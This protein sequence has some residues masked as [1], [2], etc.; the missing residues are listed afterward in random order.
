M[1]TITRADIAPGAGVP[2]RRRGAWMPGSV[3]PEILVNW[4]APGANY[5]LQ[6]TAG[7]TSGEAMLIGRQGVGAFSLFLKSDG[8][9]QFRENSVVLFEAPAG[10]FSYDGQP[11][12]FRMNVKGAGLFADAGEV[13]LDGRV[14]ASASFASR[15]V[16]T[17]SAGYRI[18]SV[19][20]FG[21]AVGGTIYDVRF[22]DPAS[23]ANTA[24]FPLD[25]R[26]SAGDYPN[27]HPGSSV[28][29]ASITGTV[30]P[31]LVNAPGG[32]GVPVYPG[33]VVVCL[34]RDSAVSVSTASGTMLL[35]ADL[36]PFGWY[37]SNGFVVPY[38]H[39][40]RLT[41]T[42]RIRATTLAATN[43]IELRVREE[44]PSISYFGQAKTTLDTVNKWV[45][46]VLQ[47][48]S[49]ALVAGTKHMGFYVDNASGDVLEFD[50][51]YLTAIITPSTTTS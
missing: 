35:A 49:T 39:D 28:G 11:H 4:A 46:F 45:P 16:T 21:Q 43:D 29:D 30:L 44:N 40:I 19:S 14:V 32:D 34:R 33:P 42:G 6:V 5:S 48:T 50:D 17:S 1:S 36:D 41:I 23:D 8:R 25:A 2:V 24:Y 12:V 3:G 20:S 9:I 38:E 15:S 51:T 7:L 27:Q 10:T 18:G 13:V 37:S 26:N 22:I 31:V 47:R